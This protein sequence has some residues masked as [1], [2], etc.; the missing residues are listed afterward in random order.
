MRMM[1]RLFARM[2]DRRGFTILELLATIL[3]LLM[4]SGIMSAGIPV[5][6]H[7]Y[8]RVVY[9]A[10]AQILLSTAM[11]SLRYELSSAQNYIFLGDKSGDKYTSV[12]FYCKETRYTTI[13]STADEGLMLRTYETV[14]RPDGK[15]T[16]YIENPDTNTFTHRLVTEKASNEH[17]IVKFTDVAYNEANQM[18]T[19]SGL[20]V[21]RESEPDGPAL[22][23]APTFYV[24]AANVAVGAE[25]GNA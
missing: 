11:S 15:V 23:E 5:A 21:V 1:R 2:R 10:N 18:F 19:I 17:L 16:G 8:K 9:T 25:V 3:I 14:S 7:A 13:I 22:A 20:Q 12:S 4:V 6:A 24:R